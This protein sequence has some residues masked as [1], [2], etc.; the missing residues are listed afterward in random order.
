MH[1]SILGLAWAAVAWVIFTVVNSILE[2]RAFKRE[3]ARRGC[4]PPPENILRLPF[5]V[6]GVWRA[7]KAD[8]K[9]KFPEFVDARF[10]AVNYKTHV[11]RLLGSRSVV[12][13]DPKIIQAILATQFQ[14]F[15]L[16]PRRRGNFFALLGSGIFTEDGAAWE[17][18]RALL[19]PQF[20]RHQIADL[21]LE[22]THVQDLMQALPS[23]AHGWTNEVDLSVL[24]FRLT[25]DSACE[26]LFGESVNSQ[27]LNIPGYAATHAPKA[28]ERD[29]KAFTKAFDDAQRMLAKRARFQGLYWAVDSFAFRR[30]CRI[31][32]KFIDSFVNEALEKKPREKDVEKATDKKPKYVFLDALV[33]QTRDPIEL[34]SQLSNI[35]LAGRDTTAGLLGWTFWELARK[36]EI[37]AKLRAAVIAD[38]GEYNELVGGETITFEKLKG[39]TYLQHVV[40][41]T[42][43]V[44][45][46]VP[47][48]W[49]TAVKDYVTLPTGGGEDGQSP[50]LV[51]KGQGVEYSINVMHRLKSIWGED[52]EEFRPERWVGRKPGWEFLPFN[53]GPRICL[54]RKQPES[55]FSFPALLVLK[56]AMANPCAPQNNSHLQRHRT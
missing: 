40:H 17:H 46:V 38:F 15:G 1:Y 24:F 41:E 16:G 45:T 6:D 49:R 18:S 44:H 26:F 21:E 31:V 14:D 52:A 28:P 53:G 4:K 22:E 13:A 20:V 56:W 5:G 37:F 30:N 25:I 8:S 34:R 23:Q 55:R 29:E 10:H 39:C 3:E 7:L 33:E 27:L 12:T 42:L 43:R 47:F 54:G 51:R 50:I 32:H 19:R 2:E 48:N 9:Q 35:L 11:N 36:P